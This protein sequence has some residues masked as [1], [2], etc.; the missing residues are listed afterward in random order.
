MVNFGVVPAFEH[1]FMPMAP[2]SSPAT[3]QPTPMPAA[4]PGEMELSESVF[5]S[6]GGKAGEGG[7]AEAVEAAA[8]H[9]GKR[10]GQLSA[11]WHAH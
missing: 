7:E 5:A 8:G 2:S 3:A 4:A 11:Q 9:S 6:E 1:S 10:L